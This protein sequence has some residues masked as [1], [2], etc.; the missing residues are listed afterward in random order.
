MDGPAFAYRRRLRRDLPRWQAEGWVDE[1]GARAI[2]ADADARGLALAPALGMLGAVLIG[3]AAMSFVAANWQAM[4]KLLRLFILLAAL[5]AAYGGAG[6]LFARGHAAL[7]H[8]GVVLGSAL[9]GANIMLIAQM[10]H[11]EGNPPDAVLTWALG[12]LAAGVLLRSGPALA[13]AIALVALWSAWQA[14]ITH[15]VHWP[16]LI[17][18]AAVAAGFAYVGWR[19]GLHLAALALAGFVVCLG[20]QIG[21]GHN[22]WIAL[23]VGAAAAVG[24]WVLGTGRPE[25]QEEAAVGFCYGLATVFAG[26]FS[27][28]FLDSGVPASALALEAIVTL[29]LTLGA[30]ALGTRSGHRGLT[31]LGYLGFSIEIL[32][33]YFKTIGSLIN[34]SLFFLVTGLVVMALAWLAWK[35]ATRN[36]KPAEAN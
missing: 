14:S 31:W 9:F 22:H 16:F 19:P 32:A 26:L 5:W 12:S 13:L 20:F 29:A 2:L 1:A 30:I 36:V 6:A 17:G 25:L 8:A 11:M 35:L 23:L 4:P 15:G 34:T 27:M 7:G 18:W 21:D 28:Q 24:G 33:L 3:F 10:Y